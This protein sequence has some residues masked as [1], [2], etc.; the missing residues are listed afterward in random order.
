[1]AERE[2]IAR[3]LHDLLGHTLSVVVLKSELAQKLVARDAAPRRAG[4]RGGRADRAR[5]PGRGAQAITGYRS[6][7]LQAEMEHVRKAL[8][9]AGID[10]TIEARPVR[11]RPGAGDGAVAGASRGGHERDPPR[12]RDACHIRFYAQDGSV[13]MEVGT[14]AAAATRRSATA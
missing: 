12:R 13:L 9:S 11:A 10:A 6:S 8:V 1:M 5:W 7:G 2:R 4:D 3:D 14:T